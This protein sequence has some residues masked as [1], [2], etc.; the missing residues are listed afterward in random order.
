MQW[1]DGPMSALVFD[2]SP[3]HV[4]CYVAQVK[5]SCSILMN[6][7]LLCITP[8]PIGWSD[9]LQGDMGN[10]FRLSMAQVVFKHATE[11]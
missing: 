10:C 5:F 2:S 4:F 6:A 3:T 8:F 7:T 9:V 1:P 11:A